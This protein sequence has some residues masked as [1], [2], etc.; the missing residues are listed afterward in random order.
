MIFNELGLL[1]RIDFKDLSCGDPDP[2]TRILY[3]TYLNISMSD[4]PRIRMRF[5]LPAEIEEEWIS[6]ISD[7]CRN[8]LGK[9]L[10][11][12]DIEE[13]LDWFKGWWRAVVNDYNE[14]ILALIWVNKM[15]EIESYLHL[16]LKLGDRY[17]EKLKRE[18]ESP[19][20]EKR[21]LLEKFSDKL[22][23]MNAHVNVLQ[24]HKGIFSD[25]SL[26]D[27]SIESGEIIDLLRDIIHELGEI[28][29]M[30]LDLSEP[31]NDAKASVL[32]R[33]GPLLAKAN[34]Q[35]LHLYLTYDS[36]S[37]NE[38][39][40]IK[41]LLLNIVTL[42]GIKIGTHRNIS[43]SGI[44]MISEA[45]SSLE[46]LR[47]IN[48]LDIHLS[49]RY[50][51]DFGASA[52]GKAISKLRGLVHLDIHVKGNSIGDAGASKLAE[53]LSKLI[54]LR[55]LI[56]DLGINSIGDFGASKLG[57]ALSVLGKLEG[58]SLHLHYNSI[59][60]S[61]AIALA[62]GLSRLRYLTYLQLGLEHNSIG[63]A[64]ASA[65]GK[66]LAKLRALKEIEDLDLGWNSIGD[67]GAIG[68][69]RV[70]SEMKSFR[71]FTLYIEDNRISDEGKR[72]LKKLEEVLPEA[73]PLVRVESEYESEFD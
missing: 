48:Y 39:S 34:V 47:S 14:A 19:V 25:L 23:K 59:T 6:Y 50:I 31:I 46:K 41:E 70:F 68:I 20:Y 53:G 3:E 27:R 26:K 21:K 63:D 51:G 36:V 18:R 15:R 9:G 37:D 13:V 54:N 7:A 43:K 61:G 1:R 42:R 35:Y 12:K 33:L 65:L 58:L 60:D 32:A 22:E 71:D 11:R 5:S 57:E 72:V 73:R 8:Y 64:G 2:V 29:Y 67:V 17:L 69:A 45:I 10:S 38:I 4:K 44:S 56:L 40:A 30:E 49:E 62:E 16:F 66:A 52:L 55:R 24:D 28:N